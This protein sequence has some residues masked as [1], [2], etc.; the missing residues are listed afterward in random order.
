MAKRAGERVAGAIAPG[1]RKRP[2]PGREDDGP[3]RDGS[4]LVPDHERIIG[5][6][7]RVDTPP[8]LNLYVQCVAAAEQRI[9]H[10][11]RLLGGGEELAGNFPLELHAHARK[12]LD[13][14]SDRPGGEHILDDAA[15][16]EE[17]AGGHCLVRDVAPAAARHV[18]RVGERLGAV[19]DDDSA[20][21]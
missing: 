18:G 15:V 20:A 10:R 1:F 12:P 11:P 19:E 4:V 13:G 6:V 5:P 17:V 2:A 7:D 21:C 16:A 9:E 3:G 14:L 8:R